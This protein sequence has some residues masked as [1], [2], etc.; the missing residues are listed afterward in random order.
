MD[1]SSFRIPICS[2]SILILISIAI[3]HGSQADGAQYYSPQTNFAENNVPVTV[4]HWGRA[5]LDVCIYKES[6]VANS[7]Y[8][9]TKLAVQSWRQALREFTGESTSW[10]INAR[11]VPNV[12]Q[13][14]SCSIK[15]Y[16]FSSYRNF[17]GYPEQSGAYTV[18]EQNSTHT[19]VQVYLSPVV[20]HG[21]GKTAIQLP[22]Y[23][24]RNSARHEFGHVLGLG[25]MQTEKGYLM[26][27]I[28]DYWDQKDQLPVT[29]L[30]LRAITGAYGKDFS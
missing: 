17:P 12:D 13:L 23:A 9:L 11:Y 1:R 5:I 2:A 19:E 15:V 26:S 18:I 27:P 14:K 29:T 25:H 3:G 21:D 24:F 30:E 22:G 7:Y 16:I 8:I 6:S 10:S 4:H 20:L 28:F